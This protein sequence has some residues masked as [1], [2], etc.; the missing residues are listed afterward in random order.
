MVTVRPFVESDADVV[1]DI[2]IRAW[3]PVIPS[4]EEAFGGELYRLLTPDWHAEKRAE[5]DAFSGEHKAFDAWIAEVDARPVGFVALRLDP[6]TRL[7]EIYLLAVDP[8]HQRDGIGMHLMEFACDEM[9]RAGMVAAMV[10]TGFDPGHTPAR[11]TYE[12]AGFLSVPA[13]RYF[14]QL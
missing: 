3:D 10:E 11:R 5:I 9:R 8:D 14:K 13:A 2:S 4:I 1:L 12:K 6:G 7:G